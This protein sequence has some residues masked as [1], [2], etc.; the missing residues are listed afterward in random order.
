M[1]WGLYRN[2]NAPGLR[3]TICA[4][5]ASG[6]RG[7]KERVT[8]ERERLH[9]L[10]P[11]AYCVKGALRRIEEKGVREVAAHVYGDLVPGAFPADSGHVCVRVRFNPLP[12]SK[13][14]RGEK[15]FMLESG[16]ALDCDQVAAL[17]LFNGHL[18]AWYKRA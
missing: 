7:K 6:A 18:F 3:Y 1:R 12:E 15:C 16:E 10:N 17:E 4:V 11:G 9:L 13:G 14:G 2:L 8:D 5:S